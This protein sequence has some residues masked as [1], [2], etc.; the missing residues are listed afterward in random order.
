MGK[1]DIRAIISIHK[2]DIKKQ[3]L[4]IKLY[5]VNIMTEM[6]RIKQWEYYLEH[7]EFPVWERTQEEKLNKI[8]SKIMNKIKE[9]NNN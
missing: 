8:W 1:L 9:L 3:E 5:R 2:R 6:S 7:K 4:Y